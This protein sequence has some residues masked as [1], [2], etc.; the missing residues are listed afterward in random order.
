EEVVAAG[1]CLGLDLST[2]EEAY[3]GKWSSDRAFVQD[4]LDGCGDIPKDMP[5]Y[6]HIDWDQ[7]AN[8]IMMDYS[9]HKG[10][11]FRNL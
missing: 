10:H 9:E 11:Y 3:N 2:L 1:I 4:L 7:T 5:A 8:D 6:I